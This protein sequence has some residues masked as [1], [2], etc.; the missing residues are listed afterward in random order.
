MELVGIP[1]CFQVA[2]G[3]RLCLLVWNVIP[4]WTVETSGPQQTHKQKK[5]VEPVT[6]LA[7]L[8]RQPTVKCFQFDTHIFIIL[9]NESTVV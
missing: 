9:R 5:A 7:E 1:I 6:Q 8:V 2:F 4:G 3:V